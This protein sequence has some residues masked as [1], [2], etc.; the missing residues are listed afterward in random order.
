MS[1]VA[2]MTRT[3]RT[4]RIGELLAKAVSLQHTRECQSEPETIP[5][6]AE[7]EI[8]LDETSQAILKFL[9]QIGS[10]A[11]RDIQKH[12]DVH[13]KTAYRKLKELEE[14]GFLVRS[15]ATRSA[16]YRLA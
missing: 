13:P 9:R 1:H 15:G 14:N 3:E 4:Q 8:S 10:A 12:I 16:R 5:V 11:P 2:H 6:D 7:L